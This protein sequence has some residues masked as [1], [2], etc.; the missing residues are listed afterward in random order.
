M[1]AVLAQ[2]VVDA[3][4]PENVTEPDVPK[5]VPVIVT[6]WPIPPGLGEIEEIVGVEATAKG[7]ARSANTNIRQNLCMNRT[8]PNTSSE[9]QKQTARHKLRLTHAT[10]TLATQN[11]NRPTSRRDSTSDK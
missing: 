6:D 3:V 7:Q 5:L 11:L 8:T 1:I 2:F 10:P 9:I 4:T